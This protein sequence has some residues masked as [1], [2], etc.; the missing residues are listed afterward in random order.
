M[1]KAAAAVCAA[2]VLSATA[3]TGTAVAIVNGE[4]SSERYP[5]MAS[6]P[7]K[8]FDGGCGGTLIDPRWVLTAA[9]CVD[10]RLVEPTGKIR[11]GSEKRS[12]GGTVRTIDTTVTHPGYQVSEDGGPNVDDLALLRLDRPVAGKSIRIAKS[13]GRVGTPTRLLGFGTTVDTTKVEEAK[14]PERL[15]QLETRRGSDAECDG[16][17]GKTRLCTP[18]QV[19]NA[20]A[21]IGDS[22]GPQ[23]KRGKGGR[24]ELIGTTSGDGDTDP[25]CATGP[26]LYSNVPAYADWIRKTIR[27]DG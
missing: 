20:M 19:P 8:G 21:C 16:R 9:H 3:M 18:S 6:I 10:P 1:A 25:R 2:S 7:M 23:I 5:F 11:I 24:W 13:P 12:S 22:G 27:G 26:G 14:F 15:Q 4:D 17:S